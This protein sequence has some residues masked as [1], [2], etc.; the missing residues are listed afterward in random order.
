MDIITKIKQPVNNVQFLAM[1]VLIKTL[2]LIALTDIILINLI[3]H[4][5]LALLLANHAQIQQHAVHA[6]SDF[7]LTQLVSSALQDVKPAIQ[8]LLV[9][10][11]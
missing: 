9:L 7:I 2:A 10:Y 1:I 6:Y 4:A 11:A 5:N 8:A 3:Q